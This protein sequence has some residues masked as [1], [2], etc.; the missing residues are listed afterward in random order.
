MRTYEA[1]GPT[2]RLHIDLTGPHPSSRQ[3]SV[4]ILTAIEAFTRYFVAVPIKRKS[5]IVVASVLVE[6]FF[7]PFGTWRTIVSDQ[8]K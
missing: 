1:N 8:G 5:A 2:N 6:Q 7:L 3:G 4:C